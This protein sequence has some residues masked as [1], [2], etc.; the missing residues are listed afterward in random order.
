M[1]EDEVEGVDESEDECGHEFESVELEGSIGL[2]YNSD[3][4][5]FALDTASGLSG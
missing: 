4:I 3:G 5:I 1:E 2:P